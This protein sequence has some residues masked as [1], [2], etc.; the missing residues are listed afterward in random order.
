MPTR[1]ASKKL[2]EGRKTP[3]TILG[4]N[5][6]HCLRVGIEYDSY[7]SHTTG[8]GKKVGPGIQSDRP[9]WE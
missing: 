6:T 3:G 2:P 5:A 1:T 7:H 4:S 8:G 9:D